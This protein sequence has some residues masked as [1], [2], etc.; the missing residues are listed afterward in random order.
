MK[1]QDT[2]WAIVDI[3]AGIRKPAVMFLDWTCARTR[4]GCIEAFQENRGEKWSELKKLG[5]R[6]ARFVVIGEVK[7]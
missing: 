7:T 1:I 6:C 5:Y 2:T 4:R 3:D